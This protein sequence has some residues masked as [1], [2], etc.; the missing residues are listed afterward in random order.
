MKILI[1][2]TE[3]T[4]AD[5][6]CEYIEVAYLDILLP[7]AESIDCDILDTFEQRYKPTKEITLG[8]LATHHIHIDDLEKCPTTGTFTL[9][10][11]VRYLI[12]HN[13][14]FDWRAL[15]TPDVRRIDTLALA[16]YF[17]PELDSHTQ[18]A[19]LYFIM[20]KGAT[21]HLRNAHSALA[22]V[23]ICLRIL[24]YILEV[25]VGYTSIEHLY[26]ISEVARIPTIMPFGKHRGE[27]IKE[28]V[29]YGYKSWLLS[30]PDVDPYLQI[31]LR[32]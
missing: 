12:G 4:S 30:Q 25:H 24:E 21:N 26:E 22:D 20:G 1:I 29:P 23:Y 9:P 11:D 19:L 27:R 5:K 13:I 16:R 32:K 10:G 14:D 15:G 6:D 18:S 8:A 2:D 28:D 7:S 3:T 31:A 17:M